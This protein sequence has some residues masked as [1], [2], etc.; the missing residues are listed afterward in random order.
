MEQ[1]HL[2]IYWGVSAMLRQEI[3]RFFCRSSLSWFPFLIV[4]HVIS[5]LSIGRR[6][7]RTVEHARLRLVDLWAPNFNGTALS[8]EQLLEESGRHLED[9]RNVRIEQARRDEIELLIEDVR[10]R[11]K[12]G[13]PIVAEGKTVGGIMAAAWVCVLIFSQFIDQIWSLG[14]SGDLLFLAVVGLSGYACIRML[15]FSLRASSK[16]AVR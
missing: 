10:R 8:L 16:V 15:S 2:R 7:R 11:L 9:R 5:T 14:S 13:E 1:H 4:L 6:V 12:N 3:L